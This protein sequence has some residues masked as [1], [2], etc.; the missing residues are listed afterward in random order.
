MRS[1]TR[2]AMVVLRRSLSVRHT[3]LTFKPFF[4]GFWNSTNDVVFGTSRSPDSVLDKVINTCWQLSP[5]DR[6]KVIEDSGQIRVAYAR[7]AHAGLYGRAG[8]DGRGRV[9]LRVLHQ[10]LGRLVVAVGWGSRRS[11]GINRGVLDG[12][13]LRWGLDSEVSSKTLAAAAAA[14]TIPQMWASWLWCRLEIYATSVLGPTGFWL[15]T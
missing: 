6:A 9:P 7:A 8:C 4:F 2:C 10:G 11:L 14:A 15:L 1:C 13:D 12:A 5:S 3:S